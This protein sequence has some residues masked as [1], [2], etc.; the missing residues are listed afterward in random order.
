M[1]ADYDELFRP[2]EGSGP[3]DDETGQTFFD[4]GT[5][6][7][8]PVKPNGDG[9][10]APKDWSRAFPPAEDESPSDSAEPAAGPAK[11]PLPPMPIGGPAP[12]PPEP[13]PAPP[14]LP[15]APPE[16][17]PARPEAPPQSPTAEAEP[18]DEAMPVSGPP[19]GGKSPLPPMPI[20]GPPPASPEPPAAPPEPT[21]P[22]EPPQPPEAAAQPPQAVEEQAHATAEPPAAPRPSRPP[23]PIGGPPPA[24]EPQQGAPH[25]HQ[26][27]EEEPK[28][29][30]AETPAAPPKSPRPP[31]PVNGPAPTRPEPPLPPGPPRRRAQPPTAPP[32]QPGQPKPIS[33]HPPPPPRPAA[34]APPA[35]GATPNRHESA[36]PP[37]PRRVRIGGPPQPPGPPEAESEAPRHSRHARRAHR[38]RPEPETDD[39]EATAVRPLPTREPMRR[40]GPAADESSTASFAW[41]QQSQPTLDRPSGP[42]PAAPGAPVES[43]PGRP[44]GRRARR[45]AESR[46]SAASTPSPLV[47]TRAQ[48]PGPTRAQ[49]PRTAAAAQPATEATEPLPDAGAPA[50]QPK[51]PKKP[52]PQRGWRRWV[53]AVTR[54]NFGLS[55]DEKYEL[56]LR[57]RIGRKPRGSYQIA[58][59]GLKGGAGKTTTTV[60]L[61]TTLTH[62]RGDRI[63][64]LDADP[65]AGNLA[66]R[67]GRSSPSSIAD[68]L[69]DPRLSHY[70]DVRAHTSVNAANLEILPTAEYT[71]AQRGLS[72]EDLRSAVDTV[73]KFYNLVLAD[74]GAGLFDPV[75]LGVLD[76]A[77]AIV[78]LTN[79]SID[80]ARQAAIALDWLRKHGYQDL[81]SRACVAIN[82]V[83]VGET[84]VSEQQ[85]V[86]DFE[87]QLQPGRVVVLPWDRHIAAGTE[88]HLDQL[89]PVYRRRVLELAAALSD[90]FERAGRR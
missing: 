32:N 39:L 86:R 83:A 49:P 48:P 29:A 3:P 68:L 85:L 1:P 81:A 87:Q 38:Y 84:N 40:N 43:A 46:T 72:G 60:T 13:P 41:L 66:E 56:D 10:S 80:S 61:G 47:P 4:P 21:A 75:T 30:A 31:M 67:S 69:A 16:P 7:P 52:V 28:P 82:H 14:E 34:F 26:D 23:M 71:S 5:A 70:N 88:I 2:A 25:P 36:E 63:L 74:C 51:K 8:P 90:D 33:G 78:I 62:V 54:I 9:H 27:I 65:G 18:P 45:R 42:M 24:P 11:S 15:P 76:T 57:T 6:Y 20:G 77:S 58:I 55:P 22:A 89:G 73:S 19:P 37:P 17:P 79:V 12:I 35:R 64:V 59:L 44:D 53:H 50:K